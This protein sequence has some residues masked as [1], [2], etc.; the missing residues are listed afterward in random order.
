MK[1]L[2]S[3]T[4]SNCT[5]NQSNHQPAL[6]D[7]IDPPLKSKNHKKKQELKKRKQEKEEK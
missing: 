4:T 7:F 3:E 2:T 6:H 1:T 5:D